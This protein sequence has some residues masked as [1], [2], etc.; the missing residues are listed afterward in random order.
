[1][2]KQQANAKSNRLKNSGSVMPD[3]L[4]TNTALMKIFY[5]AQKQSHHTNSGKL[6]VVM[7][8]LWLTQQLDDFLLRAREN[9]IT[10]DDIPDC[11]KV[12]NSDICKAHRFKNQKFEDG[13][14]WTYYARAT[15][16]QNG[17]KKFEWQPI[18]N[19]LIHIFKPFISNQSYNVSWL[20]AL[21]KQKLLNL[22]MAKWRK[23]AEIDHFPA[24]KK[25]IFFEYI[26]RCVRTDNQLSS[27][28]KSLL[29]PNDIRHHQH[30]AVYQQKNSEQVRTEL[31]HAQDR[32]LSRLF[33]HANSLG[34]S[35]LL[36]LTFSSSSTVRKATLPSISLLNDNAKRNIP[37]DIT[38]SQVGVSFHSKWVGEDLEKYADESV[39]YGSN[40]LRPE[41]EIVAIFRLLHDEITS[42]KPENK[43]AK[44]ALI[45]YHNLCANHIALLFIL[46]TGMRPTHAISINKKSQY[47]YRRTTVSDKGFQREIRICDYLRQQILHYISLQQELNSKLN[48]VNDLP[49]AWNLYDT[50][51][52][53]IAISAKS[54]RQFLHQRANGVV[55]YVLRHQFAQSAVT[56]IIH[57]L[58]TH[59]ID[60][61]M[62]HAEYGEHLGSD[63]VFPA[64]IKQQEEFLDS[65][66]AR[67][68]LKELK[69]V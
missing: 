31:F 24:I 41:S 16:T 22:L 43:A 21:E 50:N 61:L 36:T 11:H 64:S 55:P 12:K 1:M 45:H 20:T 4:S 3:R 28:T 17:E 56:S 34:V 25:Q 26:T 8:Y 27:L 29:L 5:L 2:G 44:T 59:Q 63:H 66:P 47:D 38:N 18:P 69:Y 48:L 15:I 10:V 42:S 54:L 30:A 46:L 7:M 33:N 32:Y 19:C 68:G 53:A 40:R 13:K 9:P 58:T 60:R 49:W 23:P 37:A 67:Y 6:L 51:N 52:Q 65:L 39:K 14:S 35:K 62:G 57:K